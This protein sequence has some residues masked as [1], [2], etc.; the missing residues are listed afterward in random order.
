MTDYKLESGEVLERSG[1]AFTPFDG[2][3]V[4][5]A[6]AVDFDVSRCGCVHPGQ[7][8]HQSGLASAVLSDHSDHRAGPEVQVDLIDDDRFATRISEA[9]AMQ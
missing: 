6:E 5:E 9:D 2:I 1:Q 4:A 7:Q 3:H 8:L